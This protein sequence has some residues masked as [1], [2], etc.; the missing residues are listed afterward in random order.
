MLPRPLGVAAAEHRGEVDEPDPAA[1]TGRP[2]QRGPH[3][4]A[5]NGGSSGTGAG[6]AVVAGL[7]G[8][9][10]ALLAEVVGDPGVAAAAEGREGRHLRQAGVGAAFLLGHR[11]EA[12]GFRVERAHRA[13]AEQRSGALQDHPARFEGAPRT[14]RQERPHLLGVDRPG[15]DP[16]Q[17]G[18]DGED[19]ARLRERPLDEKGVELAVGAGVEQEAGGGLAVAAGPAGLL[20]VGLEGSGRLEVDDLPDVG[21]VDAHPEGGGGDDDL[22]PAGGEV[23]LGPAPGR[24]REPAVVGRGGD[25]PARDSG[26]KLLRRR[27]CS[28]VDEGPAAGGVEAALEGGKLLLRSLGPEDL[29]RQVGAI[30]PGDRDEGV[31]EAQAAGDVVPYLGCGGGGE[32]SDRRPAAGLQGAAQEAVVGAEVVAPARDAVGLID[33]EARDPGLREAVEKARAG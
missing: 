9:G 2:G 4:V 1:E 33:D 31:A 18:V 26:R 23:L 24:L 12:R 14:L 17:R 5:G 27:H 25:A 19:V 28:A 29:Q 20:V 21:Q 32:G 15:A 30:E 16:A 6:Q 8:P 11:F 3:Q 10:D 7:A 22:D 13:V